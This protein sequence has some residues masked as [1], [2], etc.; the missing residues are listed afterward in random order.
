MVVKMNQL[1]KMPPK[2]AT[3][4]DDLPE[5]SG[6]TNPPAK[7]SS[8]KSKTVEKPMP[9]SAVKKKRAPRKPK[10][11]V[12]KKPP[13]ENPKEMSQDEADELLIDELARVALKRYF[14]KMG[15]MA[16]QAEDPFNKYLTEETKHDYETLAIILGE[17]LDSFVIVGYRPDGEMLSM[18]KYH[19]ARDKMALEKTIQHLAMGQI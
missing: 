17:Y 8:K 5:S 3:N 12:A 14:D 19:N 16:K 1:L 9:E 2:K 13:P 15:N 7:M 6:K 4:N 11:V 18:R 10:V